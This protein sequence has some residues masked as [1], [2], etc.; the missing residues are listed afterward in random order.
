MGNWGFL[1]VRR[2]REEGRMNAGQ[3]HKSVGWKEE[4]K[5]KE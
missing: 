1:W 5:M 2:K 4:R 3:N